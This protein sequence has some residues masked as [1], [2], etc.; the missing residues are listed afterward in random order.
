MTH[1]SL[2]ATSR[3]D[4]VDREKKSRHDGDQLCCHHFA[5]ARL[6]PSWALSCRIQTHGPSDRLGETVLSAL[7]R[8]VAKPIIREYLCG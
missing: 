2:L 1:N 4:L 5:S 8:Y 6:R 7:A 3:S